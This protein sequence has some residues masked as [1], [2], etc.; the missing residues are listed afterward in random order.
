MADYHNDSQV[1]D[2]KPS[3]YPVYPVNPSATIGN[4]RLLG[5]K[6]T[7]DR[8]GKSTGIR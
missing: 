1:C 2:F 4:P 5:V 7:G 8:E 3:K 6:G